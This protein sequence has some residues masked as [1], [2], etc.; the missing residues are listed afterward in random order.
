MYSH[1]LLADVCG[2]E[3]VE[4]GVVRVSFLH[5]NT[6]ESLAAH[7]LHNKTNNRHAELLAGRR[8]TDN[9]DPAIRS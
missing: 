5:Y 3:D 8:F 9:T 2:L 4:D 7:S 1:R 6:G